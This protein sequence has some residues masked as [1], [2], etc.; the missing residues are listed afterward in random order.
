LIPLLVSVRGGSRGKAVATPHQVPRLRGMAHQPVPLEPATS[1]GAAAGPIK[2]TSILLPVGGHALAAK[3]SAVTADELEY[4]I[5]AGR[6]GEGRLIVV[7]D[8]C[9]AAGRGGEV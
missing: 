1:Y 9:G 2:T 6:V 5:E 7:V 4:H 8:Q 3:D